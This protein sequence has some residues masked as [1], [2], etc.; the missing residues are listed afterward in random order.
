MLERRLRALRFDVARLQAENINLRGEVAGLQMHAA[1]LD[2]E[3]HL[4]AARLQAICGSRTLRLL[5]WLSRLHKLFAR[6]AARNTP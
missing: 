2:A 5:C 3:L 6:R 4:A 1:R